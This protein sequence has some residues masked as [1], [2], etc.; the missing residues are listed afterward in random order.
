MIIGL[1]GGSGSGKSTVSGIF[2]SFGL[3]VIDA[4]GVYHGL[5]SRKTS[6]TDELAR[7][8]GDEILKSDGS[9]CRKKLAAIVFAAG[10]EEKL[11]RL[12][13]ITHRH[14][15][16][17]TRRLYRVFEL[18]GKHDV[19]FDAP[20]LFESG[21]DKECDLTV[22][23]ICPIEQRI[24]RIMERDGV[25]EE[26]AKSRISKQISDAELQKKCDYTI[27]NDGSLE[28]LVNKTGD[29]IRQITRKE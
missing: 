5:V 25:S 10:N 18:E 22:C 12:N 20:L 26:M 24:A 21:F 16:S 19:V 11:H 2:S 3:A 29:L 28:D 9:L 13:E 14:I 17:E 15:L 23:V 27:I 4:D 1:C 7:E 6:C 8:F